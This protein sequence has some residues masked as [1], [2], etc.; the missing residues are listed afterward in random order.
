MHKN[1]DIIW[2]EVR[3]LAFFYQ[4]RT[5]VKD[6]QTAIKIKLHVCDVLFTPV[7][8]LQLEIIVLIAIV[9]GIGDN[10]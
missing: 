1:D 10:D 9:K 6:K 4:R 8:K 7:K 2:I 5:I 3:I